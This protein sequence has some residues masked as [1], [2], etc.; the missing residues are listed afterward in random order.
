[1]TAE[2][3]NRNLAAPRRRLAAARTRLL[4]VLLAALA[5]GC[6]GPDPAAPLTYRVEP[7]PLTIAIAETGTIQAQEQVI[8]KSRVPGRVTIL[9][10]IPEGEF[11]EAGDLLVRLDANQLEEQKFDQEIR[12]QNAE[13]AFI[14]ARE[15]LEITRS[16]AASDIETAEL[17]FRFAQQDLEKYRE[18]EYPQSLKEA[19]VRISLAEEDLQRAAEK[20][21]WSGVLFEE[22]YISQTE[23]QADALARKKAELD[24]DLARGDLELLTAY[25]HKRR[26]AELESKVKQSSMALE[27]T[28]RRTQANLVQAEAELRAKE[29]DFHRQKEKLNEILEKIE[30][31]EIKAPSAGQV[32]YATSVQSR[33]GRGDEQPLAEGQEVH[34]MAELIYLPA[35]TRMMAEVK[36]HETRIENVEIG[37]PAVVTM[38]AMPGVTLAGH[39]HRIGPLPDPQNF[40]LNPDL[41]VYDTEIHIDGNGA[42][43]RN[44]MSCKVEIIVERHDAVLSVPIQ[45]VVHVAG[46]PTVYVVN[47]RNETR[48]RAVETGL[49][50]N[51]MIHI[52]SGLRAGERVLLTPPLD[53]AEA[54][55][56]AGRP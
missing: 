49:D 12:V 2:T 15:E 30:N 20:A 55:P 34:E 14:R 53:A 31:T 52:K 4:P 37:M 38:D 28:R 17:D 33:R 8:I 51:R 45:S 11:V 7:G 18:G 41:K 35:T 50:N 43:L 25:E 54:P 21:K 10:L 44:G 36:I 42:R 1:M 19:Q 9:W 26:L 23:L 13:A 5:A 56:P 3:G 6:G 46:E 39:V 24:L 40:W 22:Q 48:A 47:D 27:R 32:I 29:Q 16:Q